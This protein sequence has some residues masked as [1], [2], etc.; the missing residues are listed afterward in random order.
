M[1]INISK[2][3]NNKIVFY[4]KIKRQ[5][6]KKK[7]EKYFVKKKIIIK[8]LYLINCNLFVGKQDMTIMNNFEMGQLL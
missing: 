4:Q 8:K 2:K 7:K 1:K 3:K 5:E 6:I